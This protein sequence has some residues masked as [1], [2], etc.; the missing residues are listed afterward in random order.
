MGL[1]MAR[2]VKLIEAALVA[3]SYT[4]LAQ[5]ETLV[6]A[7]GGSGGGDGSADLTPY[8]LI[9]DSYS[10]TQVV[11]ILASYALANTVMSIADINT[12]LALKRDTSDSRSSSEISGLLNAYRQVSDSMSA[13]EL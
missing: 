3:G 10:R 9:S 5:V 12:A 1:T 11:Q 4:N 7:G 2:V 8:R 13:G 6:A